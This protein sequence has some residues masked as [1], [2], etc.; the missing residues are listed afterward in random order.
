[1]SVIPAGEVETPNEAEQRVLDA[2]YNRGVADFTGL[3]A[4]SSQL[5]SIFIEDLIHGSRADSLHVFAAPV[6]RGLSGPCRSPAKVW[7]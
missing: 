1:M 7:L 4:E 6:S 3:P 2:I 5:R